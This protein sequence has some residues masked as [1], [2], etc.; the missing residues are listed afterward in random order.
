MRHALVVVLL[1]VAGSAQATP[2]TW[3]LND[4]A[5]GDGSSLTGSFVYD[6]A[7]NT[8]SGVN[9]VSSWWDYGA[10]GVVNS[11]AN[12]N[13]LFVT[14]ELDRTFDDLCEYRDRTSDPSCYEVSLRFSESLTS[15]GGTISLESGGETEWGHLND[16]ISRGNLSGN[17]SAVP[18][19]AA[20]WLFGSG[21]GLLGWLR[22]KKA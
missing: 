3:T 4:A 6:A 8:Y 17:V 14:Q 7:T 12:A 21:L 22:R 15:A 5:F 19:P 20:V 13:L 1:L 18:V 2:V 10:S 16:T 11:F 9:I